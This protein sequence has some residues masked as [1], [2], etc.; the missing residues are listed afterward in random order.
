MSAI[1]ICALASA[2]ILFIAG[3]RKGGDLLS[4]GR[5]FGIV[6]GTA[7]FLTELKLSGFQH[8]WTLYSW[9]VFATGI[10]AFLLGTFI[11]YVSAMRQPLLSLHDVRAR[12]QAQGKSGIDERRFFRVL[13]IL[14]AAYLSAFAIETVIEGTV[15]LFSVRPDLLRISFGV[16]GLH[17]IVNAVM[18]VLLLA[19][20]YLLVAPRVGRRKMVVSLM[21]LVCLASYFTLLQRYTFVV[22]G[23]IVLAMTYFTTRRIRP[24][25][26]LPITGLFVAGM[27]WINFIRSAR[28]IREYIYYNSRMKFSREFW[29]LAEP[30]MYVT[31]NLENFA[32]G[33]DRLDRFTY[34][35]LTFDWLLALAGLK[36]WMEDYF[37]IVRLPYLISGYNTFTFHW[38]YYYDF[39]PAGVAV[40]PLLTGLVIAWWYYRLRTSPDLLTMMLYSC[41]VAV[42]VISFIMN[43]LSRLD[44]VSNIVIIWFVHRFLIARTYAP[45]REGGG[46][47]MTAG[48]GE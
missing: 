11:V 42:I 39:G 4:P 43:P 23:L 27:F 5:L 24:L 12:L 20:E 9:V 21:I 40:L 1:A 47:G 3:L 37:G 6:W 29:V 30:Y 8:T 25:T 14:F 22:I 18:G 7:I 13:V 2:L 10:L 38:L 32:R 33:V 41:S 15:P 26:V 44:F 16:F 34:G 17:L 28:Y 45:V 46:S 31:M 36:H 35:Y 19:A 48:A